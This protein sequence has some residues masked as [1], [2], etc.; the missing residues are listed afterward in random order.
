M[1]NHL[2]EYLHLIYQDHLVNLVMMQNQFYLIKIISKRDIA[3]KYFQVY[4]VF[5]NRYAL[6]L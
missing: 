3:H 2:Y 6:P 5:H 1:Y 4:K